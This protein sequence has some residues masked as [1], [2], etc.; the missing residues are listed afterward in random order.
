[1]CRIATRH[2]SEEQFSREAATPEIVP[3]VEAAPG[4]LGLVNGGVLVDLV[5]PDHE[6]IPYEFGEIVQQEIFRNIVPWVVIR[7]VRD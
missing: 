1:M 5:E 4:V 3:A 7:V 2:W 6:P